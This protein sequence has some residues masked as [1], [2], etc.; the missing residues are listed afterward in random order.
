MN[1]EISKRDTD[2]VPAKGT[3]KSIR[4]IDR[5]A[6]RYYFLCDAADLRQR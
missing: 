2:I 4:P 6:R 3:K 1:T 5:A